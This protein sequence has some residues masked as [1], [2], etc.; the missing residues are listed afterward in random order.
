MAT[1][2]SRIVNAQ[3]DLNLVHGD[4]T[5]KEL[6][7]GDIVVY[8]QEPRILYEIV[9]IV[10]A[11]PPD[12][13]GIADLKFWG[14]HPNIGGTS[15]WEALNERDLKNDTFGAYLKDLMPPENIMEAIAISAQ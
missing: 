15:I 13:G 9:R 2:K 7:P 6:R 12:Q 3:V 1:F 11:C 5:S 14:S 10:W 8:R 4:G